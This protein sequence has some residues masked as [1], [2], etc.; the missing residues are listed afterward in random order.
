MELWSPIDLR[1]NTIFPVLHTLMHQSTNLSTPALG[2]ESVAVSSEYFH[3]K[4][5][6]L[7]ANN[8]FKVKVN[9]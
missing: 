3:Y 2:K 8:K 9:L 1:S 4:T 7:G 5:I 6:G